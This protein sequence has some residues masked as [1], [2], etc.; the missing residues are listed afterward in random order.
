MVTFNGHSS[1]VSTLAFNASGALL[2]SGSRDTQ[3]IVWDVISETGLFKCVFC[4]VLQPV[5]H[6]RPV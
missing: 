1:A 3:V 2:V 4:V 6:D 5:E